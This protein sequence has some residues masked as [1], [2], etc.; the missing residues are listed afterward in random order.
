M[1]T[2]NF[3]NLKD[4]FDINNEVITYSSINELIEKIN[5]LKENLNYAENI[6]NNGFKRLIKDHTDIVRSEQYLHLIKSII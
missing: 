3:K 1:L 2:E 6:A 4:L 5:F